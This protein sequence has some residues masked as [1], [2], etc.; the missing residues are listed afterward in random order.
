MKRA[1]L[2]ELQRAAMRRAVEAARAGGWIIASGSG[3]RVTLASLFRRGLLMRRARRGVEGEPDAAYEYRPST[4]VE[5]R[6][7]KREDR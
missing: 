7:A 1:A 2:T 4:M 6:L 5:A 3:D